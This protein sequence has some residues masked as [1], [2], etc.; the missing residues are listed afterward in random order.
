MKNKKTTS[1]GEN[2]TIVEGIW[3]KKDGKGKCYICLKPFN[4]DEKVKGKTPPA[5]LGRKKTYYYHSTCISEEKK[6]ENKKET[7]QRETSKSRK[8]SRKDDRAR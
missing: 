3:E 7:E 4:I 5:L 1:L 8:S 6:D 2:S